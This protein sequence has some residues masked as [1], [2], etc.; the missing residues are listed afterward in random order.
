[1]TPPNAPIELRAWRQFLALAETLHYG[2]AARAA[3]HDAAA[4]D[5]WRSSSWSAR[6]GVALFERTPRA[7]WR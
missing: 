3:A 2:R 7:A 1:M 6:L 4:A 5:A